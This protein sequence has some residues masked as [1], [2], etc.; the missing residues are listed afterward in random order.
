MRPNET[1]D[2]KVEEQHTKHIA[3]LAL[4]ASI[5]APDAQA[6]DVRI[7]TFKEDATFTLNGRTFTIARNQD[8]TAMVRGEF[9]RTSRACPPDCIQPM[10]IADGVT[11]VGELEILAFLED[12]V[13]NRTGLLLD[14]RGPAEFG[15]GSIPG[16]VNVP[17]ETLSADNRYRDD[18]LRA[19]GAV[20]VAGGLDFTN[21]MSL[22]L[23]SG[24]VWSSDAP[25][26]VDYLLAAGYP[27]EKLFYYRGGLQAWVHVGMT[28]HQTQN[29]G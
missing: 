29:P 22:T 19:L 24:G 8:M 7:T 21:A 27:P 5:I 17:F 6:Q 25:D 14:T 1:K 12:N 28:L 15:T 18:I 20:D 4:A 16:A 9:A 10:V 3:I 11:T 26:A 2:D 23:F 13:T